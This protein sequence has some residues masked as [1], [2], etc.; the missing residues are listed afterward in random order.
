MAI[1][2]R[3]RKRSQRNILQNCVFL[4]VGGKSD[5]K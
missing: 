1:E 3:K 4:Q 5:L 2:E